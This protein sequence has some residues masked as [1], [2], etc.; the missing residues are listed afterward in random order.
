MLL[1]RWRA[2][3]V[4]AFFAVLPRVNQPMAFA[5][6]AL[7]VALGVLPVAF[8]FAMGGLVGAVQ[9]GRPLTVPLAFM[10]IVFVLMQVLSPL[11]Q[12]VGTN[13]GDAISSHLNDRLTAACVDPPGIGHLE[14]PELTEDLTVAREFDRGMT[15]PPMFINVDFIGRVWCR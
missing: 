9:N 5:W 6:Y 11:H 1:D 13:L 10:G 4:R 8:A 12:A 2:S 7:L 15:G 14:D 3:P